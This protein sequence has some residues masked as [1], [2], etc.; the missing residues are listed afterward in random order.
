MPDIVHLP[1]RRPGLHTDGPRPDGEL[2]AHKPMDD[3]Q[4]L[5]QQYDL[6]STLS[7]TPLVTG[8]YVILLRNGAEV[9][10]V[11]LSR[12]IADVAG[13]ISYD[14]F[15]SRKIRDEFFEALRQGGDLAGTWT[16][17][18]SSNRL[19]QPEVAAHP[20]F[21]ATHRRLEVRVGFPPVE[22]KYLKA[23]IANPLAAPPA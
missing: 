6:Q 23:I 9:Q 2:P 1:P 17:I 16:A 12:L 3:V 11:L 21:A 13:N 19:F 4:A 18:G 5:Q 8:N 10:A 20:L 7:A 15:G 14:R 22:S